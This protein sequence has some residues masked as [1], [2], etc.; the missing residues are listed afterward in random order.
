MTIGLCLGK[1][2]DPFGR[3]CVGD[4]CGRESKS[5]YVEEER[6]LGTEMTFEKRSFRTGAKFIMLESFHKE[7]SQ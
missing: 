2:N 1:S 5:L 3:V 6:V 4:G 7:L